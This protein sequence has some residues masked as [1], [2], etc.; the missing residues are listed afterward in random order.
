MTVEHFQKTLETLMSRQP[1]KA[2]TIELNA[3][4]RIEIDNPLVAAFSEGAGVFLA[5]GGVPVFFDHE[6]VN[7][8]GATAHSTGEFTSLNREGAAF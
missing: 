8:M 3:G 7:Q 1:F 5:P 2:F 4:Q 6:S